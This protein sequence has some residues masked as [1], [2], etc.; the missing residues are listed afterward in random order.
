VPPY[1]Y[2]HV[3]EEGVLQRTELHRCVTARRPKPAKPSSV[4]LAVRADAGARVGLFKQ[5][6]LVLRACSPRHRLA[7]ARDFNVVLQMRLA[8]LF[9]VLA[10][11]GRAGGRMLLTLVT[12]HGDGSFDMRPGL[13]QPGSWYRQQ[14]KAGT[15]CGNCLASA[16]AGGVHAWMQLMSFPHDYWTQACC[17][18]GALIWSVPTPTSLQRQGCKTLASQISIGP[19][20]RCTCSI[21][22]VQRWHV[23]CDFCNQETQPVSGRDSAA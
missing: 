17:G 2:T 6:C 18:S 10:D 8:Q 12:Y 4:A 13:S 19:W 16:S 1:I 9:G 7:S 22:R 21:M 5:Y 20:Y 14:D 3:D 15:S 23:A 11:C